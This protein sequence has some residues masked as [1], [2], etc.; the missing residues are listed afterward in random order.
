[1]TEAH[2]PHLQPYPLGAHPVNDNTIRFSYMVNPQLSTKY[3]VPPVQE[4]SAPG[5]DKLSGCGVILCDRAGGR[6]LAQLPF[7]AD[8]RIGNLYCKSVTEV[9]PYRISYLFYEDGRLVP[10]PY[11]RMFTGRYTYGRERKA[12]DRKA[13]L[14]EW[15]FDW[16]EDVRPHVPYADS[17]VYLAHVRGFTRHSSSGVAHRGTF[18]G[19]IEKLDYL[20]ESGITT[21]ELQPAYDFDEITPASECGA[22][23]IGL[24]VKSPA[25]AEAEQ[26]LNYW[27]YKTGYYYA[28]KA[29]YSASPDCV[30][31]F[32]TLVREMHRRGMELVMQFYFPKEINTLEIPEILRFWV[33]EYHVDGFHLMGEELPVE[34]I[35]GDGLLADTKIWHTFYDTSRIFRKNEQPEQIRLAAYQDDYLYTMRRFLKGDD[36][37][38]PAVL[39][40]LRRIP[41]K[42]GRIHYLTNY[43]G[44]T[45]M[46]L[47]SYDRKHNEANGEDNRDGSDYNC[48]WNCGEE[49]PSRR[50]RV[51]ELR[52]RQYRNALTLLLLTG[53]TPMIF[54]GD[55]F[56]NSQKGN[57]NPYCQDNAV[58]WL[59]WRDLERNADLY[60]FWRK[61]V[62]LRREHPI[63]HPQK[64]WKVM[65]TL[66]CGYPDLSFHGAN[67][68]KPSLEAYSRQVG[69]MYCGK[70]ARKPDGAEDDF[71]YL[72]LNSYWEPGRLAL[73]K[74]P[75]G[76]RWKR[77]LT[78][79]N[80]PAEE[81]E[82]GAEAVAVT[83]SGRCIDLYAGV[84]AV[85]GDGQ[86]APGTNPAEQYTDRTAF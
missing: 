79:G 6:Q 62:T 9:N 73:P 75:K 54:M 35:A 39:E 50:K 51:Q 61:M 46:D 81:I 32:K 59:D 84:P 37:L 56:G 7:R 58:T 71:F 78:T 74:L 41:D 23:G 18:A 5:A 34:L 8:E 19:M 15:D 27:G 17:I 2:I 68:W 25:E 77:I 45:L 11:A 44:F 83:V 43:S 48:S 30:T 42:L 38:V 24:P 16:S 49:G 63:F 14:P 65:D 57:N 66:S 40:Q 21:V 47:V 69:I 70:Y 82:T 22:G 60:A 4:A 29:A 36:N 13:V 55:E 20:R 80:E 31:E 67:A 53:S 72:G 10:D 1:M 3:A 26:R 33:L 64:A 52:R 85:E 86:T 28:P 76:M 12:A